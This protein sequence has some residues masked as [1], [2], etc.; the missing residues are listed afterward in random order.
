VAPREVKP[1]PDRRIE[2]RQR[3]KASLS[4]EPSNIAG[5]A[6]AYVFDE[7]GFYT[8][9]ANRTIDKVPW[10]EPIRYQKHGLCACLNK[11][12]KG[13]DPATYAKYAQKPLRAGLVR[14][15]CPYFLA[16]ALSATTA[17]GV[18]KFLGTLPPAQLSK[19]LR[20]IIPLV[21]PDLDVCPARTDVVK[22]YTAPFLA[23]ELRA[24]VADLRTTG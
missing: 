19:S 3:A 2:R 9:L 6:V 10:Y 11:V 4:R 7:S 15:G 12:A 14:V 21:C 24:L 16:E 17:F 23:E 20:V 18:K 1:K 13:L 8:R 22:T 5:D